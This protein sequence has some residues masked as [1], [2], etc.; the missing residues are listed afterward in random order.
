MRER[1]TLKISNSQFELENI[2]RRTESKTL[3]GNSKKKRKK[4]YMILLSILCSR[5][6]NPKK[7]RNIKRKH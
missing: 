5:I 2:S 3:N 4:Q 6:E 1:K 7:K